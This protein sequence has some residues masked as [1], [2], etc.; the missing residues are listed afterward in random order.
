MAAGKGE[1]PRRRCAVRSGR[2]GGE[3]PARCDETAGWRL[4]DSSSQRSAVHSVLVACCSQPMLWWPGLS[5][6][7]RRRCVWP[8]LPS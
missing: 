3:G 5:S 7:S 2:E 1:G 8:A 6:L 4:W